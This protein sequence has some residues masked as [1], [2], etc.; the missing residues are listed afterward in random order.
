MV[1]D[2]ASDT[3]LQEAHDKR[4]ECNH[5]QQGKRCIAMHD[6]LHGNARGDAQRNGPCVETQV[7]LRDNPPVQTMQVMADDIAQYERQNENHGH[8]LQ[9]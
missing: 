9:Y 1:A 5:Q 3:E 8:L 6:I 4:Q 7:R 2:A